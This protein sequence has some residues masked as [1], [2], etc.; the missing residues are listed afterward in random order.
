LPLH[1][2]DRPDSPAAEKSHPISP[3]EGHRR[4]IHFHNET[5]IWPSIIQAIIHVRN[6]YNVANIHHSF[7]STNQPGASI[8][9]KPRP[10]SEGGF[11][12]CRRICRWLDCKRAISESLDRPLPARNHCQNPGIDNKL[13]HRASFYFSIKLYILLVVKKF[14]L[15]QSSFFEYSHVRAG[16]V[17]FGVVD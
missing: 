4:A 1:K 13:D 8:H 16:F 11:W 7:P 3:L 17:F 6:F 9:P 14:F 15:E 2:W 12:L 5:D 10:S